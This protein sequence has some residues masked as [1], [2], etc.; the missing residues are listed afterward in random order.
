MRT[1]VIAHYMYVDLPV[2]PCPQ[3]SKPI[4]K[5]NPEEHYSRLGCLPTIVSIID[6]QKTRLATANKTCVSIRGR[7][8]QIFLTSTVVWS[9][10]KFGRR[11]SYTVCEHVRGPKILGT[12]VSRPIR[13][14]RDW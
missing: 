6:R 13:M 2:R 5:Q 8:V 11:F 3:C 14:G 9:R 12:L 7:P 10:A 1:D 4:Q